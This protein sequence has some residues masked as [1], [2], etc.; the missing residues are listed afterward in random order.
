MP[1]RTATAADAASIAQFTLRH[2]AWL[3]AARCPMLFWMGLMWGVAGLLGRAISQE[4]GVVFV[5]KDGGRIM[6]F[7]DLIPVAGQGC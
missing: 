6:G 1:V 4:A 7:C 2:G 5:A 3:I